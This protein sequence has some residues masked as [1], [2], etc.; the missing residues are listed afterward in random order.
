MIVLLYVSLGEEAPSEAQAFDSQR[1]VGVFALHAGSLS[2]L[3]RSLGHATA[4]LEAQVPADHTAPNAFES[5]QEV[6]LP[7]PH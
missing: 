2:E 3:Q 1:E 6:A 4:Q 7:K 5:Q